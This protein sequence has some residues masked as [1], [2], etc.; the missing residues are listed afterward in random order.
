MP[1]ICKP[2]GL[3]VGRFLFP[4]EPATGLLLTVTV[5]AFEAVQPLLSVTVTVYDVVVT[6][7]TLGLATADAPLVQA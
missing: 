3:Q 6:G 7:L 5:A 1:P 4:P 2:V